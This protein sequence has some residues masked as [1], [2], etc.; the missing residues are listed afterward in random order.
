MVSLPFY[1]QGRITKVLNMKPPEVRELLVDNKNSNNRCCF[2]SLD[3]F[4]ILSSIIKF[5]ETFKND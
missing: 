5:L 4:N 3:N 2:K 1:F